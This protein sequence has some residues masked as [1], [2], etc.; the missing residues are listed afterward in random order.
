MCTEGRYCSTLV[1]GTVKRSSPS[2]WILETDV[3]LSALFNIFYRVE[4]TKGLCIQ[5]ER[6]NNDRDSFGYKAV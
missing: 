3:G 2:G 1:P 4:A 6:D 5:E